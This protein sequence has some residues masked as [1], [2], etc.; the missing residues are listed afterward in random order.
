MGILLVKLTWWMSSPMFDGPTLV[1]GLDPGAAVEA[2][3]TAKKRPTRVLE[4]R[5]NMMSSSEQAIA[6]R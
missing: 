4:I 3:A 2:E 6:R 5:A 1:H